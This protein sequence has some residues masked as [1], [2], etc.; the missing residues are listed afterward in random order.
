VSSLHCHSRP[1]LRI[2]VWLLP[3]CLCFSFGSVQS[4]FLYQRYWSLGMALSR[5]QMGFSV[6]TELCRWCLQPRGLACDDSAHQSTCALHLN[7]HPADDPLTALSTGKITGCQPAP[8]AS[9]STGAE[10]SPNRPQPA[11]VVSGAP[12]QLCFILG[13]NE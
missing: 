6:F 8:S 1:A 2:Q 4:T 5:S 11:R 13:T 3:G 10:V 9:I 7:A 12:R